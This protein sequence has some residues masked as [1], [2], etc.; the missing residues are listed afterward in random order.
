MNKNKEH[1]ESIESSEEDIFLLTIFG[2][3]ISGFLDS[4]ITSNFLV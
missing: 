1:F 2:L 3:E 4:L